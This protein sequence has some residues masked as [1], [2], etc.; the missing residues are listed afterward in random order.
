MNVSIIIPVHNDAS[1]LTL[2][3]KNLI[4]VLESHRETKD[5]EIVI[6]D[7]N[8][9]DGTPAL[10]DGPASADSRIITAHSTGGPTP[11]NAIRCGLNIA[12]GDVIVPFMPDG[13][14]DPGD[15]RSLVAKIEE[16]YDIVHGSRF[17]KGGPVDVYSWRDTT[18]PRMLNGSVG[19]LFGTR[20]GDITN[21]FMAFR[22]EVLDRIGIDR[23]ESAGADIAMEISLEAHI[24]GFK[25]AEVPVSWRKP[26]HG[27]AQYKDSTGYGRLIKLFIDGNLVSLK[28]IFS[29]M[30]RG[31]PVYML[32][33]TLIGLML[34]A[35]IFSIAGFAQ[36]L[37]ILSRLSPFY[38]LISCLVIL[39]TF[40]LRTWRC[41]V[42]LKTSGYSP[43]FGMILRCYFFGFFANF[44]LPLGIGDFM[45]AFALKT[46]EDVPISTCIPTFVVEGAMDMFALSAIL[47][48][49]LLLISGNEQLLD[50]VWFSLFLSFGLI[51]SLILLYKFDHVIYRISDRLKPLQQGIESFKNALLLMVKSPAAL[52]SGFILTLAVWICEISSIYFAS[53]AV[54][55][56]L[57]VALTFISGVTSFIAQA[58]PITPAGIGIHE[59]AIAGVLYLFGIAMS[60]GTSIALVDHFARGLVTYTFGIISTIH[61]GFES[62]RYFVSQN[63]KT[64]MVNEAVDNSDRS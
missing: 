56:D 33:A 11:G 32:I 53:R 61:I 35:G 21:T 27:G 2:F 22:K 34:L 8:G 30:L 14:D 52:A 55:F 63:R 43:S 24:H 18:A 45:R 25:S 28:D 3:L 4:H 1:D 59:G 58:I 44:I 16:G 20:H 26:K 10:I 31:S 60:A 64:D 40:L 15:I 17:C 6:V 41:Q 57:S 37:S 7:D 23:L 13:S 39:L 19:L 62:R 47:I 29:A 42:L 50:L 46:T 54:G 38:L 49:S 9:P 48:A 36:V 5:F 51:L 12:A